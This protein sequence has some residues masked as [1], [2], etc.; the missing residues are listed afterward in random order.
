MGIPLDEGTVIEAGVVQSD[1]LPP[2]PA[3][4]SIEVNGEAN[5]GRSWP[6]RG[7]PLLLGWSSCKEEQ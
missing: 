2:A 6:L 3:Q 1:G 5:C 7:M 4:I